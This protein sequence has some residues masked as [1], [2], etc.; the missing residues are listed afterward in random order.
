MLRKE[1]PN[2]NPQQ[3]LKRLVEMWS[4]HLQQTAFG[5]QCNNDCMCG[6]GWKLV[7]NCGNGNNAMSKAKGKKTQQ[8]TNNRNPAVPRKRAANDRNGDSA[9]PVFLEGI[10]VPPKK[11]IKSSSSVASEATNPKHPKPS[12][13]LVSYSVTYDASQPLGFFCI[14][15]QHEGKSICVIK[16][17]HPAGQSKQKSELVQEGT[18]GVYEVC[19]R[20]LYSKNLPTHLF[21]YLSCSAPYHHDQSGVSR[22]YGPERKEYQTFSSR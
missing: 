4:L 2:D 10:S 6:A 15:K 12:S 7:F 20:A 18:C 14:T 9:A 19:I 3:I 17:L 13:N 16:S 5:N 22:I 11:K 8:R 1:H 21:F